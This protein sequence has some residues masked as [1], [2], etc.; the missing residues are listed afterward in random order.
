[1]KDATKNIDV[2]GD[3]FEIPLDYRARHAG[4]IPL[5]YFKNIDA[6]PFV[7]GRFIGAWGQFTHYDQ[8]PIY[9]AKHIYV[10]FVLHMR[11]NY[12]ITRSE[13]FGLGLRRSYDRADAYRDHAHVSPALRLLPRPSQSVVLLMELDQ[14]S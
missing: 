10:E 4:S 8:V 5:K 12:T 13:F 1:V 6:T 9:F 14:W 7:Y 11:Q 3:L 2:C